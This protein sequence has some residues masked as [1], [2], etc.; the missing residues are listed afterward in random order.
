MQNNKT[1]VWDP[2]VRAL[3]WGLVASFGVSYFSQTDGYEAH[4]VAGYIVLGIVLTRITWGFFGSRYARFSN[5]LYPPSECR[6]H[7]RGLL[8]SQTGV[9]HYP[10]HN[11]LGGIMV[12]ALLLVL[13]AVS[14]SG[15][16]LDAAENRSG[17]LSDFRLFL[18]TDLI[19][20]THHIST[21][22]AIFLIFIHLVGVVAMSRLQRENLVAAMVTGKKRA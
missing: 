18:Y 5:F 15:V 20:K 17:P 8:G 9:K 11:P 13:L 21:N 10:G 14:L 16:A 4:L 22:L 3:H 6:A 2:L 7:V 19:A 12:V 1:T